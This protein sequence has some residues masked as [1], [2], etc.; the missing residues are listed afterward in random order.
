MNLW[1]MGTRLCIW[2]VSM[3]ICPVSRSVALI[4]VFFLFMF[5]SINNCKKFG[6]SFL[7]QLLLE[8]GANL[9]AE[10]EDGGIPLHDACAGG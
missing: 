8:R 4:S 6:F 5:V 10:D 7:I 3:A 1:K 2:P 9:E